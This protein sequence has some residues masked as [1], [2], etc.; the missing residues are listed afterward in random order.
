M[1]NW[2]VVHTVNNEWVSCKDFGEELDQAINF[3]HEV[4]E[5]EVHQIGNH[6]FYVMSDP[7]KF[8]VVYRHH[9]EI[10]E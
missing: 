8:D 6:Y 4:A 1:K 5:K 10:I 3:I 2:I 9:F 7:T